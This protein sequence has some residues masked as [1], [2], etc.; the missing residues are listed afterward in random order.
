MY[1][2]KV[3]ISYSH[4]TPAHAD[5]VLSLSNQLR[6]D[7][8]DCLLDQ[9]E[10]VPS[11]GWP[12]WM[13]KQIQ[14]ADFVFMICTETYYKRVM[15][16]EEPGVGRGIR[17]EGNLIYNHLYQNDTVNTKFIPVLFKDLMKKISPHLCKGLPITKS[18][19]METMRIYTGISLVNQAIK[20]PIL[21]NSN[22]SHHC[23]AKPTF[24][25]ARNHLPSASITYPYST[26]TITSAA[27]N[28]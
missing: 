2:P 24:S 7:G 10:P 8:I 3:F 1:T 17:W 12:R 9:Y 4:D 16:E 18:I 28:S 27:K 6:S 21:A 20:S 22:Y 11:E 23:N 19:L 13:D 25:P 14:N 26:K 15:G 5:R